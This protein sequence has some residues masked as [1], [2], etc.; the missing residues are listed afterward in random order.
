M[1]LDRRTL[2]TGALALSA[3][4]LA[5][6]AAP[7]AGGRL[8]FIVSRNGKDVGEHLMSFA[9]SGDT[10]SV[11]TDA[12]LRIK[13]GPV[14]VFRYT[15][16]AEEKW[17]AGRIETLS[18]RTNSNGKLETVQASRTANGVAVQSNKGRI[19]APAAANPLSHW[20]SAILDGPLFNPQTGKMLQLTAARKGREQVALASGAKVA[21]SRWSLTGETMIDDW[22]DSAGVWV[23]L[24]GLLE[25]KSTMEYRRA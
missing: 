20:N 11:T 2:I 16:H 1:T 10:V 12:S 3:C 6:L 23:A 8:R 15:H 18:T 24:R 13:L 19:M 9:V 21:A 22:Y 7:P 17:K 4:P 14:P 25:D 5:A